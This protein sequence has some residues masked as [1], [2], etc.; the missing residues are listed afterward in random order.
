VARTCP[1]KAVEC[2]DSATIR[3]CDTRGSAWEVQSCGGSAICDGSRCIPQVCVPGARRC[4]GSSVVK[5][6]NAKGTTEASSDCAESGRVCAAGNCVDKTCSANF[7]WDEGS[8][9]CRPCPDGTTSSGGHQTQCTD[10]N[11]CLS[12]NGGCAVNA[13]CV[14]R[15]GGR[16]CKCSDGYYGSGLVCAKSILTMYP[17]VSAAP[18]TFRMGSNSNPID[19]GDWGANVNEYWQHSVTLTRNFSM[20]STDLTQKQ[21]LSVMG[22]NPSVVTA[23]PSYPVG[24]TWYQA[25]EFCN[26]LSS[27]EGVGLAYD[28][29]YGWDVTSLGYRL[30]SEAEFEY[31]AWGKPYA[32]PYPAQGHP[33]VSNPVGDISEWVWDWYVDGFS[34]DPVTDPTGPMFPPRSGLRVVRGYLNRYRS[35]TGGGPGNSGGGLFVA[36]TTP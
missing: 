35:R 4:D 7:F 8:S 33:A 10:I 2:L 6:C 23:Y 20:S 21:W 9:S 22:S 18:V 15:V 36:R 16:D 26:E 5:T 3:T 32:G 34:P 17:V 28:S 12:A 27:L 29:N 14:N 25:V 11:E 24:V 1:P 19:D 13:V 30:P 31:F